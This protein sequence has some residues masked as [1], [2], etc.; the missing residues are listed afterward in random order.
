[1]RK[2]GAT[3]WKPRWPKGSIEPARRE[4]GNDAGGPALDAR[5]LRP[6]LQPVV[7][8]GGRAQ[9][10]PARDPRQLRRRRAAGPMGG[11][12]L[13]APLIGAAPAPGPPWRPFRP[14]AAAGDRDEPV[15]T[16]L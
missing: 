12:R 11:Q 2:R 7:R 8:G 10:R 13:A 3:W 14:A 5:R 6:R 4:R 16:D 15:R 1:M 9:R